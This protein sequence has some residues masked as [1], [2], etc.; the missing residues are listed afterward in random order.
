M[1]VCSFVTVGLL[2][3]LLIFQAEIFNTVV[4]TDST[5]S[6]GRKTIMSPYLHRIS[7][8]IFICV[9]RI[10][11]SFKFSDIKNWAFCRL[12]LKPRTIQG[13]ASCFWV[14]S[15]VKCILCTDINLN[16]GCVG[17]L[18]ARYIFLSSITNSHSLNVTT[19]PAYCSTQ[20]F[21]LQNGTIKLLTFPCHA[22][23]TKENWFQESLSLIRE[24]S[25]L[26]F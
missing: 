14:Q 24:C 1:S 25:L 7:S 13:V 17:V 18:H 12:Q 5:I 15:S 11:N 21:I 6:T 20:D 26:R 3:L 2:C 9:T 23:A 8:T 19:K 4:M 10:E 22:S 16:V